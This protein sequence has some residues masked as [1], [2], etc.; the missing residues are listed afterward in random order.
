MLSS[1]YPSPFLHPLVTWLMVPLT[2]TRALPPP[3]PVGNQQTGRCE[4]TVELYS[5]ACRLPG[6]R[7]SSGWHAPG[8][9]TLPPCLCARAQARPLCPCGRCSGHRCREV[10]FDFK[11]LPPRRNT[12]PL[13]SD[14]SSHAGPILLA[15][16][17]VG[18]GRDL[19]S[20]VCRCVCPG[21]GRQSLGPGEPESSSGP[22]LPPSV[23]ANWP[24][25]SCSPHP[26][27]VGDPI[28]C[29]HSGQVSG[30]WG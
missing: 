4:W 24:L 3:L 12:G 29:P 28:C 17:P 13:T 22:Q 2:S 5:A 10:G 14:P 6:G 23:G 26:L 11:S 21:C 27:P 15:D 25:L 19:E 20:C 16:G 18:A 8:S 9:P 7:Y 1:L 30:G